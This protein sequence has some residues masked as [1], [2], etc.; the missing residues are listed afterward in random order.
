MQKSFS[1]YYAETSAQEIALKSFK[2]Q[3]IPF[4]IGRQ[5]G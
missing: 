3:T 4:T 1:K 5:H 2:I